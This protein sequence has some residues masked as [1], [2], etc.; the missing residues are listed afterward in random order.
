M[1][2]TDAIGS[3]Q[4]PNAT[5]ASRKTLYICCTSGVDRPTAGELIIMS[6]T[7]VT[8]ISPAAGRGRAAI[9][10]VQSGGAICALRVAN[11]SPDDVRRAPIAPAAP[12]Y[13]NAC[14]RF[15]FHLTFQRWRR[16][17]IRPGLDGADYTRLTVVCGSAFL[18]GGLFRR[19]RRCVL[20]H[21]VA[22]VGDRPSGLRV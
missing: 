22:D 20:D 7:A 5:S 6:P 12:M 10:A 16:P 15:M 9:R 3:S 19:R 14:R 8:T 13:C 4:L 1:K 17:D 18:R 11:H 2:P 21:H